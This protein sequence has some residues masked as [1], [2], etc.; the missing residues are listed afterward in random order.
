MARALTNREKRLAILLASAFAVVVLIAFLRWFTSHVATQRAAIRAAKIEIADLGLWAEN[1]DFWRSRGA[2]MNE[3]PPPPYRSEDTRSAC[4]EWTQRSATDNQLILANLQ[5]QD[6]TPPG[7]GVAEV[8]ITLVLTGK[9]EQ[10][11]RWM[12]TVHDQRAFREMRRIKIT[13]DADTS[14]VRAEV[15]LVFLCST[16]TPPPKSS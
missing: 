7:D 15:T 5:L 14:K 4:V 9:L 13:S 16:Q 1:A 10:L 2:W 6:E 8:G 3:F 11:V 12:H